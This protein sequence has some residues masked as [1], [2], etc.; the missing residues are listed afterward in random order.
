MQFFSSDRLNLQYLTAIA[1]HQTQTKPNDRIG[2]KQSAITHC[3]RMLIMM[4][5]RCQCYRKLL[6]LSVSREFMNQPR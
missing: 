5:I 2:T 1:S 3:L 4:G 6:A